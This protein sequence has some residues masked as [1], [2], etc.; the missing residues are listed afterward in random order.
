VFTQQFKLCLHALYAQVFK[1]CAI[2]LEHELV[3]V[4]TYSNF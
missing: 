2:P 1:F 4:S 3:R